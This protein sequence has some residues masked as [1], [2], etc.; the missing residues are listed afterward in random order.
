MLKVPAGADGSLPEVAE[1]LA[2]M[3]VSKDMAVSESVTG[4]SGVNRFCIEMQNT[5]AADTV[6]NASTIGGSGGLANIAFVGRR[7]KDASR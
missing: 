1:D 6:M 5:K 7:L 3:L 2:G 4:S